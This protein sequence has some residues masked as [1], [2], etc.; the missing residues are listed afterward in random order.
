MGLSVE[1]GG[2]RREMREGTGEWNGT[3][4][5]KVRITLRQ[6]KKKTERY[7]WKAVEKELTM[8]AK[9]EAPKQN[10]N[11]KRKHKWTKTEILDFKEENIT[12]I[13]S[14]HKE[15][16]EEILWHMMTKVGLENTADIV[17]TDIVESYSLKEK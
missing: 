6:L 14:N 3:V 9:E 7:D 17:H 12:E 13:Y 4:I 8:T 16:A 11:N 2:L 10:K 5:A 1:P 15:K